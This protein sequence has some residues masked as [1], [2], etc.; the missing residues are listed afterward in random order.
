MILNRLRELVFVLVLAGVV[1]YYRRREKAVR[2]SLTLSQAWAAR[3][4]AGSTP[5][6]VTATDPSALTRVA[7]LLGAR[8]GEVP[9]RVEALDAKVR[10]LTT[11]LEKNRTAWADRW[12]EAR[13]TAPPPAGEPHVTVVDLPDGTLADAEALAKCATGDSLGVTIVTAAGDGTL[14]V[15]VGDELDGQVA[16]DIA[17]EVATLAGGG[18]GG[19]PDFATGGGEAEELPAAAREVRDRLAAEAGFAT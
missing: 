15:A 11:D 4:T 12:W 14:A 10:E 3:E 1:W 6:A 8:P 16:G 19:G 13:T 7:D 18:A 5:E 2:E 9:E 17:R